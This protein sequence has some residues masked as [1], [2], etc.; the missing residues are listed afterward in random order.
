MRR[1][2][3]SP[4]VLKLSL[5]F[6]QLFGALLS[7]RSLGPGGRGEIVIVATISMISAVAGLRNR[8]L[9]VPTKDGMY[10]ALDISGMKG[11]LVFSMGLTCA[12]VLGPG[13]PEMLILCPLVTLSIYFE[14]LVFFQ[15]IQFRS[16]SATLF[17]WTWSFSYCFLISLAWMSG[18]LSLETMAAAQLVST[19][20]A[21]LVIR[22]RIR[23][24]SG[25]DGVPS[26]SIWELSTILICRLDRAFLLQVGGSRSVG[27]FSVGATLAELARPIVSTLG[28]E[29]NA[30]FREEQLP[31]SRYL[32]RRSIVLRISSYLVY[33]ML[34]AVF[35]SKALSLVLGTGF[36]V[37]NTTLALICVSEVIYSLILFLIPRRIDYRVDLG[38]KILLTTAIV[39]NGLLLSILFD[40][41]PFA[42][43][44]GRVVSLTLLV[45]LLAARTQTKNRTA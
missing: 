34:V 9:K 30:G 7:A 41:V 28:V 12:V 11:S 32:R 27:L 35:G 40:G 4:A 10:L 8:H 17:S 20:L 43:A 1:V 45:V 38:I 5:S 16:I 42:G 6:A 37:P 26:T 13:F 29:S 33:L 19:A 21:M 24:T 3:Q 23:L 36:R 18:Y 25:R 15:A 44:L 22:K 2:L 31:L 14:Y 39:A